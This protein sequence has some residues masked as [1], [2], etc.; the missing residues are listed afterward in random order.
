LVAARHPSAQPVDPTDDSL[1]LYAV[2][3]SGSLHGVY[4]GRGL[5]ITA[6][7]VV[8]SGPSASVHIAGLD[9]AGKVIKLSPFEQLDLALLSVDEEKLP[10]SLRLRLMPLCQKPVYPGQQVVSATPEG[11]ARSEIVSPLELPPKFRQRFSTV[12][13]MGE[14][15]GMSGSGVFDASQT[16]LLG[17]MS[18]KFSA[19]LP[20]G[21]VKDVATYFVPAPV[22][23]WFIP[24][25]GKYVSLPNPPVP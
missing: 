22:I 15:S 11:T 18:R 3:V 1:R 19:N 21:G 5:I 2:H 6:A 17:I 25:D 23:R 24:N 9:M 16:C 7:H 10:V 13:K 20:G 8:G 12:I 14:T 4:L